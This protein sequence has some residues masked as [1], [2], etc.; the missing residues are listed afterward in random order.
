MDNPK[1]RI[2]RR[3]KVPAIILLVLVPSMAFILPDV[4]I[5]KKT[6]RQSEA[7][8]MLHEVFVAATKMKAAHNTY[9]VSQIGQLGLTLKGERYSYWYA[10][11][12]IPTAIP[13]SSQAKNPC[14]VTTPPTSVKPLATAE[15]FIVVAKGNLDLDSTC[16]EWSL[17]ETRQLKNT[18]DDIQTGWA[19]WV[20]WLNE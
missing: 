16:D 3:L 6:A 17:T 20:P 18:L 12:G 1:P 19:R 4:T 10:V 8:V 15:T 9:N 5:L 11:N 14:D 7:K 13:G 2:G